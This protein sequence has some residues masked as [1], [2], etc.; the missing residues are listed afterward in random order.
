MMTL[1][2]LA[3]AAL[4][5]PPVVPDAHQAAAFTAYGLRAQVYG[6]ALRAWERATERH[7]TRSA[8]LTVIDYSLPSATPRLWVVNLSSNEL[9]FH[10][11]VAHGKRSGWDRMTSWSNTVDSLQSS[12]GVSVTA[13]T[14]YGKHGLSLRLDGLEPSFNANNRERD[15]VMHGATYVSADF[16]AAH[17]RVGNSWGCPAVGAQVA[18]RL[19][20][21]IEGGT[22]LVA[23]YPDEGWRSRS[24]FV[25]P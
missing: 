9:L 1:T 10:E 24:A 14:Y 11:R 23:W 17:G 5:A 22:L 21:A 6:D 2:A 18:P 20:H 15:I 16:A 4:A 12:I 7:Q 25:K 8:V 19:I 13:E 3:L